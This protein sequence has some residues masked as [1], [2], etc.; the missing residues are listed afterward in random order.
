[1]GIQRRFVYKWA[2]RFSTYGLEGLNDRYDWRD[3]DQRDFLLR[4]PNAASGD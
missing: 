1:V 4:E 3:A 2:E